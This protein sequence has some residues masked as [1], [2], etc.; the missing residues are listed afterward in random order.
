MSPFLT[1][2]G[3]EKATGVLAC[4]NIEGTVGSNRTFYNHHALLTANI[5]KTTTAV[6]QEAQAE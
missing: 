6:I 3:F 4:L 2:T 1:G 5:I